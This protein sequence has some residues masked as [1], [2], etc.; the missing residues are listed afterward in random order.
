MSVSGLAPCALR[1]A[2]VATVLAP[3]AG[4]LP[5]AAQSPERLDWLRRRCAQLVGYFDYY[6]TSRGENS[7]GPRNH[8]R[9]AASIE[10]RRA[11]Y[12]TGIAVMTDL[13]GRKA[14]VLPAPGMPALEPE[15]VEAP[16]ITAPTVAGRWLWEDRGEF[17]PT[18]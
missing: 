18:H 4:S 15:D 7:D 12:R 17:T 8:A 13:L 11:H 16:D 10:C 2:A 3:L 1:A 14:F 5:A 9:V 6:G